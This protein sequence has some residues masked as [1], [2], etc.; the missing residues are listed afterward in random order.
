M[1]VLGT[2][3]LLL[4]L[5]EIAEGGSGEAALTKALGTAAPQERDRG[6]AF[7]SAGSAGSAPETPSGAYGYMS[8]PVRQHPGPGPGLP[9]SSSSASSASTGSG[10]PVSFA[11]G[12]GTGAGGGSVPPTYSPA[13]RFSTCMS[14]RM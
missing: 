3:N 14:M 12:A 8:G 2:E 6:A 11:P 10:L 7:G 13:A 5:D 4:V 1:H 9:S